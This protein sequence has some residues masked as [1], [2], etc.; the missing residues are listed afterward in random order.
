M[1]QFF[2]VCFQSVTETKLFQFSLLCC[3]I[4]ALGLFDA[5]F[6]SLRAVV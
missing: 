1:V 3:S 4:F 2:L 5:D 6:V